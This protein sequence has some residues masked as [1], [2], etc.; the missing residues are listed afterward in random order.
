MLVLHIMLYIHM[1]MHAH[2][3]NN[4]YIYN[5]IAHKCYSLF[6]VHILY[7]MQFILLYIGVGSG[8]AGGALAPPL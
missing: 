7:C 2:I 8:G 4:K 1:Y 3:H 6:Y 5:C